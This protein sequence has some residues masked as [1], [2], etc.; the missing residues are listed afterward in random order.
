MT[1]VLLSLSMAEAMERFREYQPVYEGNWATLQLSP[2]DLM[3]ICGEAGIDDP[4]PFMQGDTLD[5]RSIDCA[6]ADDDM[7]YIIST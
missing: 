4:L 3:A 5:L 2:T 7:L 6:G 1:N